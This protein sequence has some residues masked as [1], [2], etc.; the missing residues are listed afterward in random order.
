MLSRAGAGIFR[1]CRTLLSVRRPECGLL[2]QRAC[3]RH[4]MALTPLGSRRAAPIALAWLAVSVIAFADAR[5]EPSND[6]A[7]TVRG[8][9]TCARRFLSPV[10]GAARVI[11]RQAS[12]N[13][14]P[15]G[16]RTSSLPI[17]KSI[18]LGTRSSGDAL[19]EALGAARCGVGTLASEA[20]DQPT[21]P[22]SQSE[23]KIDL[24]I[25]SST[26]LGIETDG[27][28]LQEIYRR[29]LQLGYALCPAEVGPQLRLPYPNQ[30]LG[31]FLR[32]AMDPI[33]T[34]HGELVVFIVGN[35]GAGL[36]LI[37]SRARSDVIVPSTVRFVFVHRR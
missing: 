5:S 18:V 13:V 23:T 30:P 29:A 1:G 28:P 9:I 7:V 2:G 6:A 31:E 34:R 8:E 20:L 12:F 27:A 16:V 10:A 3:I 36:I 33:A 4:M 22:V 14:L 26:E 17:R 21:F 11:G 35:G 25:L 15:G 32:I 24:V 19:H 37:G